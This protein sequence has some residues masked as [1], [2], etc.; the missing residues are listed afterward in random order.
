MVFRSIPSYLSML[1]IKHP[2]SCTLILSYLSYMSKPNLGVWNQVNHMA[3]NIS[4]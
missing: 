1:K 3:L 2:Y 4:I